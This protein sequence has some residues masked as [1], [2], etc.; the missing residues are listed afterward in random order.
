MYSIVSIKS[1]DDIRENCFIR[2][3][4]SIVEGNGSGPTVLYVNVCSLSL[5]RMRPRRLTCTIDLLPT[6]SEMQEGQ[7]EDGNPE[8]PTHSMEEY[9]DSIKELSQSAPYPYPLHGPLRGHRRWMNRR[10]SQPAGGYPTSA[11]M[12][13]PV[14]PYHSFMAYAPWVPIGPSDVSLTVAHKSDSTTLRQ[15][16]QNPVDWLFAQGQFAGLP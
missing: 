7:L 5:Y 15:H 9:V 14:A 10:G 11:P 8:H 12:F 13:A 6:I 1:K 4:I 3:G 2:T 16:A